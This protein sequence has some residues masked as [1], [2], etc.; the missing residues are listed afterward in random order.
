MAPRTPISEVF[1]FPSQTSIC[2]RECSIFP[3]FF[4]RQSITA[5]DRSIFP[6]GA[7]ANG[8]NI[9]G[10]A[11]WLCGATGLLAAREDPRRGRDRGRAAKPRES[12]S[13]LFLVVVVVV[14]SFFGG[15]EFEAVVPLL[16]VDFGLL[17]RI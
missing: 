15:G 12:T 5:G 17:C 14:F 4:E 2:Q 11:T 6:G 10:R 13:T 3:C 1:E 7:N 9:S 8:S 16:D